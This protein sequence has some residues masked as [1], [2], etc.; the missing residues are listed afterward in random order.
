[1]IRLFS[2]KFTRVICLGVLLASAVGC[3]ARTGTVSGKVVYR[4]MPL[5]NV[6][7][8]FVPTQGYPVAVVTGPDGT[9]SLAGVA[10]GSSK[11][12]VFPFD[13]GAVLAREAEEAARLAVV[14]SGGDQKTYEQQL[15]GKVKQEPTGP[16][17]PEKYR[18]P[19]STP[20]LHNVTSATSTFDITLTD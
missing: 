5:A 7:V 6:Q 8:N 19:R 14:Q 18:D 3:G 1:M 16:Q 4:G 15:K 12:T 17:L 13:T 10:F 9:Y 11:V 20:L 2:C